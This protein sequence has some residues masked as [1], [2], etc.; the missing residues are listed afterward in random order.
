[1][2]FGGNRYHAVAKVGQV[3][4]NEIIVFHEPEAAIDRTASQPV[5]W[6][7]KQYVAKVAEPELQIEFQYPV[8]LYLNHHDISVRQVIETLH[9][10]RAF[11][12]DAGQE[13]LFREQRSPGGKRLSPT[14]QYFDPLI[15][16]D[17]GSVKLRVHP[18]RPSQMPLFLKTEEPLRL[19]VS[20]LAAAS[21]GN[22]ES[23]TR[24]LL[25]SVFSVDEL[26]KR[27][28]M[29]ANIAVRFGNFT[30]RSPDW[31]DGFQINKNTEAV[32]RNCLNRLETRTLERQ[33]L[34]YGLDLIRH[35]CRILVQIDEDKEDW[36]LKFRENL[37]EYVRGNVPRPVIIVFETKS[38]PNMLRGTGTLL[39]IQQDERA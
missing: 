29:L 10:I 11:A 20:V 5:W 37:A 15:T 24:L 1:V 3:S 17:S 25:E 30:L 32:V 8:E 14:Y 4:V 35:W 19:M 34:L 27:V 2:E 21:N 39:K 6:R 26:L 12:I 38:L 13:M 23:V 22:A 16:V 36:T 28:H 9:P 33:G 7:G 31:P 18:A